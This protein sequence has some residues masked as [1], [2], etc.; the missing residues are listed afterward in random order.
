M[1]FGNLI[2]ATQQACMSSVATPLAICPDVGNA[3]LGTQI[4]GPDEPHDE[5]KSVT[6]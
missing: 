2:C 5:L 1:E 4:E 3:T 6:N